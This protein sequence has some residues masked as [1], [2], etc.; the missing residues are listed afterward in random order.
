M[1][2]KKIS[3]LTT[4]AV[5]FLMS[6]CA[7]IGVWTQN[8][9]AEEALGDP[10]LVGGA[11]E[12]KYLLGE[13]LAVPTAKLTCGDETLDA[14]VIV[15]KPSGE[16]V[17]SSNVPLT[18]GGIYTVIYRAVFD[19]K[20]KTVEKN[21]TVQTPLFSAQSKNSYAYYGDDES[22]YQTGNK[23]VNVRLAEGDI[24]TYNDVIDLNASD[25]DFLEFYLPP[26][27]GPGTADLRKLSITLTDLHDPSIS[28]TV[29]VNGPYSTSGDLW[30]YDYAYVQAG[31]QNQTPAGFEAGTGKTHVG[32]EWGAPTRFSFYGMHGKTVVVGEETLK[33]TYNAEKNTVFA[34]GGKVITLDDLN[35]FEN[36]WKGF[37]TGEVKMTIKGDKFNR[38]FAS[39]LITRIGVNNLNQTILTDDQAPEIT[40]DYNGFDANNLP[41]ACMGYSYPVFN[42]KAMDKGSGVLPVTTTV[43]YSYES[44]QRYQVAVVDGKFKTARAGFYTVEYT[45]VD[46]YGNVGVERVVV[47]CKETSSAIAVSAT[48]DYATTAKTGEVIT[49]AQ[50]AYV[51]GTGSVTTYATIKTQDGAEVTLDDSF[52]PTQAG[53][54]VVTL[55]AVDMLGKTASYSY[56]VEITV[57]EAPVFLDEVVMPQFF[58]GG[59]NYTMPTLPAYDFSEGKEELVTTV[60]VKDGKG[61][62]ELVDGVG[63]FVADEDG[64]AT[65]VY[66]AVGKKGT[67]QKE[68]KVRVI[69]TWTSSE[70]IDMTK[71]IYGENITKVASNADIKVSSTTDTE[72][73]FITPVI[74]H[75]F[76]MKF[77]ITQN[78]FAC[79]QLVFTDYADASRQFTVEIDKSADETQNALLRINGV[80]TRERASAGFYDGD[81]FAIYYDDVAKSF[82]EGALLKQEVKDAEG[83]L[84]AGF[85]SGLM[86]VSVRVIGVEGTAEVAWNNFAGQ[87]LSN[88]DVDTIKPS[89]AISSEYNSAYAYQSVCEIYPAISADVLCPETYDCLTV[90][91]PNGKVVKD[92]NGL[93]LAGVPFTQSYFIELTSYGSYSVV[94][95][96]RDLFGRE[97][98]YYYAVFVPDVTEPVISL[99]GEVAVEVKFGAEVK[100]PSAFAIDNVDGEVAIY[101]Y[102]ADPDGI[103]KAV[104]NGGSFV[105]TKRGVYEIR[106]VALDLYGNFKMLTFKVTVV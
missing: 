75:K 26:S 94:Y 17:Q 3:V 58:V 64:Y 54:Y 71:Y 61:E 73:Q 7:T 72:Y 52:R 65:I 34:N 22:Q 69:N 80:A 84:F 37:T 85:S 43:Y 29:V 46:N 12:E 103:V 105:A 33:L 59:N 48:G 4:L 95:S 70:T 91:D 25:G 62:R 89:I 42:A 32:N 104:V 8:A 28:L 14:K 102:V 49:P 23:G 63:R 90:Y 13:Y 47:E 93:T 24:L 74:A 97:Q 76:S 101:T 87:V 55:Y 67:T 38:P 100:V 57:N 41:T 10:V 92:I 68:Y 44:N 106:Y 9:R 15:K 77:A 50:A 21:F 36:A 82:Q 30:Y 83:N 2:N 35:T 11:L 16:L 18:E 27:D 5:T 51:G 1:K 79:L 78:E 6:V 45:S 56:D 31:G 20:V 86:Y 96:S 98:T 39:M 40:I 66:T 19:G 53:T 99:Q 88:L 60:S 81:V